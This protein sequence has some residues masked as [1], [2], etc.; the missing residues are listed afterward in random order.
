MKVSRVY[1]L[2]VG[3]DLVDDQLTLDEVLALARKE[4]EQELKD[5][6]NDP[7][8][9]VIDEHAYVT[10]ETDEDL[11]TVDFVPKWREMDDTES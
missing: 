9:I 11:D 10:I 2:W 1:E 8:S 7:A 5:H 3:D 6:P 4:R